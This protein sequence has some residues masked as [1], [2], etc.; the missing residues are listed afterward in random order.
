MFQRNWPLAVVQE[1]FPGQDGLVRAVD[2]RTSKGV[3]RR[4]VHKLVPLLDTSESSSS[5]RGG[6]CSGHA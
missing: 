2:I 4:P 3:Y 5:F 1:I 6:G